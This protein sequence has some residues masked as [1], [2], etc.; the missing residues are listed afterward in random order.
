MSEIVFGEIDWNSGDAGSGSGRAS[1]FMRLTEGENVVR[2]MGN[3]VQYYVHWVTTAEGATRKINSPIDDSDLVRRL[4][5][6]GFKRKPCW[7]VKVLDRTDDTFK[8]LEIGPQIYNGIRG[9]FNHPKWGKVTDYDISVM[10]GPRGSQPL[11]N[12]NPNPKEAIPATLKTAYIDF[13]DR[14]NLEKLI[15]PSDRASVLEVMGWIDEVVQ[16]TAS[17]PNDT[18]VVSQDGPVEDGGFEFD[19]S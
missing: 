6:A 8:L 14:I 17:T 9:L 19:F 12:V 1:D 13:N 15:S 5:D 10:R 4:E 11:Y 18:E 3:P 16:S 7:L 2:V